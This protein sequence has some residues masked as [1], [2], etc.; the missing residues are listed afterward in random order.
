MLLPAGIALWLLAGAAPP[1][2]VA[3]PGGV[4][5]CRAG[6]RGVRCRW[7][8]WNAAHGWASLLRQGGRV[9][10]WQP[11]RAPQFLAELLGGQIGLATPLVFLLCAGGVAWAAGRHGA[12]AIRRRRCWR[13]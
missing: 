5:R 11:E 9:G 3:A 6:R 4:G 2:L 7:L 13:R 1:A 10:D 12:S 8:W